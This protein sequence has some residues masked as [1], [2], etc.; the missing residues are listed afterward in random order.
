MR[1]HQLEKKYKIKIKNIML[2]NTASC[3]SRNID[4]LL[5][6]KLSIGCGKY[7]H[8]VRCRLFCRN[9]APGNP[10]LSYQPTK[11]ESRS[12]VKGISPCLMWGRQAGRGHIPRTRTRGLRLR[13]WIASTSCNLDNG[14]PSAKSKSGPAD[15]CWGYAS[16]RDTPG[17]LNRF[18]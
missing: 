4:D 16:A 15:A 14:P 12:A 17:G 13:L 11:D 2:G 1:N 10:M 18:N 6:V 8:A 7:S 9:D 3:S 5:S